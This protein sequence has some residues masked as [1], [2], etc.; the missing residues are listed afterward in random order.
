MRYVSEYLTLAT[1]AAKS[2]SEN[3]SVVLQEGKN[4]IKCAYNLNFIFLNINLFQG[5]G[6]DYCALVSSLTQLLLDSHFR[7]I[8]GFQ[9]LIQ[10]DWIALGHP[11]SDR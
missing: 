9:S 1:Q 8:K 10:K 5:D 6:M 7:T 3:I 2:L 11:F 4:K